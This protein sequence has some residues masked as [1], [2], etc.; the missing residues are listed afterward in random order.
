[1]SA[2]EWYGDRKNCDNFDL[3]HVETDEDGEQIADAGYRAREALNKINQ[4]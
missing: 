2:L 4:K 1:V 3:C